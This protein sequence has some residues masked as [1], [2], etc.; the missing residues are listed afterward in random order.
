MVDTAIEGII[1]IDVEGKIE[2]INPAGCS[3]F[4]YSGRN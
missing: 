3:L 2:S 4:G 1:T